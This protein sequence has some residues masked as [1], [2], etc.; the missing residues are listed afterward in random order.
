MSDVVI[1]H[2]IKEI[3]LYWSDVSDQANPKQAVYSEEL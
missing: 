2:L 3:V 1:R